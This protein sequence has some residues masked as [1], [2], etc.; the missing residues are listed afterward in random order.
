M[1]DSEA[2]EV[3]KVTFPEEGS[4]VEGSDGTEV[5]VYDKNEDGEVVGW[6][7]ELKDKK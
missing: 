3:K 5:V 4:I 6:H 7:K 2:K 1:A